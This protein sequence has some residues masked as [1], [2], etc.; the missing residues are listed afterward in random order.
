MRYSQGTFCR[1][2]S[3]V[4]IGILLPKFRPAVLP[5]YQNACGF[6]MKI[7][8]KVITAWFEGPQPDDGLT[9]PGHDFFNA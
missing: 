5:H 7:V 6:L 8:E 1:S 9:V 4:P 2:N 3:V